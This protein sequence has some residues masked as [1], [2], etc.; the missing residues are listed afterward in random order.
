MMINKMR[1]RAPLAVA[2]LWM[3]ALGCGQAELEPSLLQDEDAEVMSV[4]QSLTKAQDPTA[5]GDKDFCNDPGARCAAGE[6]DC[7]SDSQCAP[8]SVCGMNNGARFGMPER[9]DVCIPAHCVDGVKS[10]DEQDIDCGGAFCSPCAQVGEPEFCAGL[11]QGCA[12]GQGD[13][14]GDVQCEVGLRCG[15]NNGPQ[16][17]FS[18]SFDVCTVAHCVDGV[19][20][21]DET[22]IDCGGSCGVCLKR[23][24]N[25]EANFCNSGQ[26]CRVGEG[27]CDSSAQC[28]TGLICGRDNGPKFAM[29]AGWDVCVPAHCQDSTLSG[30][31]TDI[32]CGGSC[33]QCPAPAHCA[34]GMLDAASGELGLDCGGPCS[35]CQPGAGDHRWSLAF[36]G[37]DQDA[38]TSVVSA[39]NGDTIV[40]GS[41][42]GSASFGAGALNSAGGWDI[43]V[44]SLRED[45]SVRWSKR[46]GGTGFDRAFG[47]AVDASGDIYVTGHFERTVDFGGGA[48]TSTGNVDAFLLKLNADGDHLWSRGFGGTTRDI[49]LGVGVGTRGRVTITG[50]FDR[51]ASFGGSPLNSAGS[52]DIFVAQFDAAT[53]AHR[54]SRGFGGLGEDVGAAL[55]VD[56]ADHIYVA[57]RFEQSVDFGNGART[58]KGG[59]DV[60]LLKLTPDGH[61]DWAR[62]F[63]SPLDETAY[64]VATNGARVAV[65]GDLAGA[66][67]IAGVSRGGAG[68]RAGFVAVYDWGGVALWSRAVDGAN[69]ETARAV[70]LDVKN[71]VILGGSLGAG[72]DLGAGAVSANGISDLF[73]A[74]YAPN[75]AHVWSKTFGGAGHQAVHALSVSA[76]EQISIVG[77]FEQT[78]SLGGANFSALGSYDSLV[79]RLVN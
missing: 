7:D 63:G 71:R 56:S 54:W 51:V 17:G 58:S 72:A 44:A 22:G 64:A 70:A 9:W 36:S 31:E 78:C 45:G 49:G 24:F 35:P 75:G 10:G 39:P 46:F 28:E 6:G 16:F 25:G 21:G 29:P 3:N 13:C 76:D 14:D 26:L 60:F 27:D 79:G 33:G 62:T 12:I 48:L 40:A 41:F 59:T 5:N 4:A 55:A 2:L 61:F 1:T 34:N 19:L 32:D 37:G 18:S 67:Q 42:L 50:R 30:D 65:S 8:G 68:G 77:Q 53:G 52:Q 20:S 43:V 66:A 23:A 11:S 73:V 15:V 47:V 57:G 69:D 74:K 38:L